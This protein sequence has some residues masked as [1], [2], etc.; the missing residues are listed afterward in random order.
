MARQ[1]G[2]HQID[3]RI[4]FL[5]AETPSPTPW[6]RWLRVAA[7]LPFDER[8]VTRALRSHG[9]G[10]VDVRRRGLA[11]DVD[12]LRARLRLRGD[13]HAVLVMT[14]HHDRPWA[15]VCTGADRPAVE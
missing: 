15:L 4:G 1:L 12:A 2:A 14:R 6:G 7:S 5:T 9:V 8:A 13:R 11:G 3:R 10:S